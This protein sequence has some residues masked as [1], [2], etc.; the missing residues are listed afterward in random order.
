MASSDL[1]FEDIGRII[2]HCWRGIPSQEEGRFRA[3][4]ELDRERYRIAVGRYHKEELKLMCQGRLAEEAIRSEDVTS[5]GVVVDA[6]NSSGGV[7]G[8]SGS[9]N[10]DQILNLLLQHQH[11]ASSATR[12]NNASSLSAAI[13]K[14]VVLQLLLNQ[15]LAVQ[16][17]RA[18][19]AEELNA[20][21]I[22][23]A[24]LDEMLAKE[25]SNND[26]DAI[27]TSPAAIVVCRLRSV[28]R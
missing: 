10:D 28:S 2:G 12:N 15:K 16:Q 4:A 11:Q 18:R 9:G 27:I 7:V 1:Q 26:N 22:K 6:N 20:L 5:G 13:P 8:G 25:A 3:M 24:L 19:L 21:R 17:R 23:A 14:E